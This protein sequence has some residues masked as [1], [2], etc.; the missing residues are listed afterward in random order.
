M[1]PSEMETSSMAISKW[2]RVHV[3]F[4]APLGVSKMTQSGIDYH[5]GAELS[6]GKL[7]TTRV[8]RPLSLFSP[9]MMLI[10]N[11]CRVNTVGSTAISMVFSSHSPSSL[12]R[13]RVISTPFL[14]SYSIIAI[15]KR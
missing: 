11:T 7:P 1:I 3:L 4:A 10:T 13:C 5:G 12:C 8:R 2:L 9:S 6:S 14:G 15:T